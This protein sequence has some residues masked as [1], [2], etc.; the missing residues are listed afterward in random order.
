MNGVPCHH[1]V[2]DIRLHCASQT[3]RIDGDN[4][5]ILVYLML[6]D[7]SENGAGSSNDPECR[8]ELRAFSP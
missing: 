1:S 2:N 7:A 3:G 5:G 4:G 6:L 8:K